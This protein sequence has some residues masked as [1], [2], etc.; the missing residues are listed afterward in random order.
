MA[1]TVGVN[2]TSLGVS[3]MALLASGGYARVGAA[4]DDREVDLRLGDLVDVVGQRVERDV[5]HD[6]DDLRVVVAGEPD[7]GD[8]D[9]GHVAALP[10]TSPRT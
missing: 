6:L 9:V 10:T 7:R 1:F 2:A 8:V 3:R 5:Q 4:R